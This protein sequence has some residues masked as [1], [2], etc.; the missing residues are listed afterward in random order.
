MSFIDRN[1]GGV[2]YTASEQL[3]DLPGL[4]HAFSTRL[5]GVSSGICESLDLAP[6]RGDDPAN[7]RENFRRFCAAAGVDPRRMVFSNQV[8]GDVV[9][10]CTSAD[11]GCGPDRDRNYEADGL[12]TDVPG[13]PLV[14]FTADC[15]PILLCD[16]VRAVVAAVHAGWRGTALGIV[17]RAVEKMRD[18]Y[19]CAPEDI[20]AAIGP[21]IGPCC[22]ETDPDVPNAMTEAMGAAAL[23]FIRSSENGKFFVDL[24]G[25]NVRR[26]ERAGL[27][28][29]NID[30]SAE[31][32]ACL[33]DKYWSHRRTQ[34][35]RGS[36]AA[37]IALA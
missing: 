20:R 1:A 35:Q 28:S 18:V 8:H 22:F 11:G 24:K 36:M 5:G 4:R 32:T 19:G 3:E 30:V 7:V 34:G 6:N 27:Q 21:S 37:V 14:V 16:P 31:C 15:V 10:L 17:E 29:G 26:L 13:L 23:P 25:L 9:R 12:I 2:V 33:P